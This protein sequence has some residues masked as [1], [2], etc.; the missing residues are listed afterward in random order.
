MKKIVI[1]CA[2]L[3]F[4]QANMGIVS[5]AE[6]RYDSKIK[7]ETELLTNREEMLKQIEE[8]LIAQGRLDHLKYY[9]EAIDSQLSLGVVND[10]YSNHNV[11][12]TRAAQHYAPNGAVGVNRNNYTTTY[13]YI[14]NYMIDREI[15]SSADGISAW[16]INSGLGPIGFLSGVV[17][18]INVEK[19]RSIKNQGKH[20][21]KIHI[22]DHSENNVNSSAYMEWSRYPYTGSH[23][24]V[25]VK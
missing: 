13:A 17:S 4:M 10:S 16:I 20:A 5:A 25:R 18:A 2:M 15:Y 14:P 24:T 8:Q 9:E 1:L 6:M 23:D 22:V 12:I 7:T 21:L 11:N 3:V 19:L